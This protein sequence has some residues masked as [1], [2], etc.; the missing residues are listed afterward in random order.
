MNAEPYT[1]HVDAELQLRDGRRLG[2]AIWGSPDG[3]PVLL[4][5]GSPASRLFAPD[6]VVTAELGCG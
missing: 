1:P 3:A 4:C 2:Y 6:P 5:H